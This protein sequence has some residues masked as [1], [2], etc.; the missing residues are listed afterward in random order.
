MKFQ[1]SIGLRKLSERNEFTFNS[2]ILPSWEKL[3]STFPRRVLYFN[4]YQNLRSLARIASD[5]SDICYQNSTLPE[6]RPAPFVIKFFPWRVDLHNFLLS[7]CRKRRMRR[8]MA[9]VHRT[10]L[11]L[12]VGG[13]RFNL[14][15]FYA[16]ITQL[17]FLGR[18]RP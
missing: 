7:D 10:G 13:F 9:P 15:L 1:L 16:V 12:D 4:C 3:S 11:H 14:L 8:R 17:S 2:L 5:P 18:S 6:D